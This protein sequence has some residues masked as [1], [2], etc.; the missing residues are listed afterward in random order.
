MNQF[1][2]EA[3]S[4]TPP[5]ASTVATASVAL[6]SASVAV[7]VDAVPAALH[8][9]RVPVK[10]PVSAV[11]CKAAHDLASDIAAASNALAAALFC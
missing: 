9:P 5:F 1:G 11:T 2:V 10:E 7:K 6:P 4:V 3:A 8:V